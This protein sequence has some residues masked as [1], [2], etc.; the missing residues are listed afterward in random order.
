MTSVLQP[1]TRTNF[2]LATSISDGEV[3]N[4]WVDD[5]NNGGAITELYTSYHYKAQSYQ[6]I[7]DATKK[8]VLTYDG[9]APQGKPVFPESN[10]VNIYAVHFSDVLSEGYGIPM[11]GSRDVT[12]KVSYSQVQQTDY[13]KSELLWGKRTNV[14]P[15]M[16][17]ALPFYHMMS[18]IVVQFPTNQ[19]LN[20]LNM[21]DKITINGTKR[22]CTATISRD[23]VTFSNLTDIG[24]IEIAHDFGRDRMN[25]GIIIPQTVTCPE[26]IE[27]TTVDGRVF[28]FSVVGY[29]FEPGHQY[30]FNISVNT[31]GFEITCP[32]ITDWTNDPGDNETGN[33]TMPDV[34]E[35]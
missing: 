19:D 1:T 28:V 26:F 15:S 7:G 4:V 33:A 22:S 31:T 30:T 10:K 20:L 6:N 21:I 34:P 32:Q 11:G 25:E 14:A 23:T 27:L 5:A 13:A 29:A 17:I 18:N 9:S 16:M 12:H 2:N 8:H 3:V 35:V 24:P